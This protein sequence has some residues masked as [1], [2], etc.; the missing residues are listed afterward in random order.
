MDMQNFEVQFEELKS[1]VEALNKKT[2][3]NKLSMI[4]F[5][6]DLD[7]VGCV[8]DCHR[9]SCHGYGGGDVFHF[10]GN[11]RTQGQA[12]ECRR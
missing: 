3:E 1:Q 9:S 11:A 12:K 5:S 7:K 8:C 6:G 4:V 10:L 2:A